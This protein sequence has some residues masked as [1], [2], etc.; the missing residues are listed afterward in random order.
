MHQ[1]EKPGYF[2]RYSEADYSVYDRVIGVRFSTGAKDSS[3]LQS[4]YT[5]PGD[6]LGSPFFGRKSAAS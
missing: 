2:T 6:R 5:T 1:Q 4:I 3:P